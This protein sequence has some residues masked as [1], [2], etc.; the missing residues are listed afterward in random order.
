M[1]K[2]KNY[3]VSMFLVFNASCK[4]TNISAFDTALI[5][6]LDRVGFQDPT[7]LDSS[8]KR[9]MAEIESA[10]KSTVSETITLLLRGGESL[11]RA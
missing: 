5:P 4:N 7:W 1:F 11:I 8:R 10:S 6:S 9:D 2:V 3:K